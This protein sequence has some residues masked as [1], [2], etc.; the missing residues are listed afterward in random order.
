MKKWDE[1]SL[2]VIVAVLALGIFVWYQVL[3]TGPATRP[4]IYFLDVGQGDAEIVVLPGN[5]KIMTDAGPDQ[6]VVSS[7]EKALSK[8]DKYIDIG[9]I[10]HPQ[11][12]H[13]NGYNYL[14]DNYT[15]GAFI[16]N[17]RQGEKTVP[18]WAA[19]LEKIKS[20]NVPLVTLAA[21]DRIR[22]QNNQIDFL[23]PD[24]NFIQSSE[25]N[26]TGFVELVK[27]SE[28]RTLLVADI[29]FSV[30]N[31]LVRRGA[32]IKADILKAAHHG[33]KH[34][35]GADFLRAVGAKVA[36]IGVGD[37]NR[38]GHPTKE[39]L[40]RLEA[41]GAKIFRTDQN[42]TVKIFAEGRK[43]KIIVKK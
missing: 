15:F 36:V 1:V 3:F 42:G 43:L 8:G 4:E 13:F 14:L 41:A 21:G 20:K 11:L 39:A 7:I 6:K 34:S 28:F 2:F 19:L 38:Y 10:S 12:D 5:I 29:G 32:D 9:I 22:Y 18:Q 37:K 27:T 30:E 24:G 26:D 33:S 25:L 31:Y 16:W 17:G 40:N 35:S 23:S